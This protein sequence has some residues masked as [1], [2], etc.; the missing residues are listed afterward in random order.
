[1]VNH[2]RGRVRYYTLWNEQDGSYWNLN[3]NPEEYGRLLGGFVK[4]VRETDARAKVV[5]GGQASLEGDY[6]RHAL[7]ACE[8]ASGIDVFAYHTYPGGYVTNAAPE[9]MD[10][11]AFGERST[12]ALR[13]AVSSYPGIRPDIQFW[14]D[15]YNSLPTFSPE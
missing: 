14:D 6:A 7:A 15:E 1:M 8:C 11:G 3:A 10:S 13:K 4:A 9:T 5:Y 2:F 12:I